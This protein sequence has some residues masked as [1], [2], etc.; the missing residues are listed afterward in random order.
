M[1]WEHAAQNIA[2]DVSGINQWVDSGDAGRPHPSVV[3]RRF[4]HVARQ[5]DSDRDGLTDASQ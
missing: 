5:E 1:Q 2:A 3:T 4:Y